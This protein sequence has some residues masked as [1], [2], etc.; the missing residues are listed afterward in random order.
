MNISDTIVI[1]I[2]PWAEPTEEQKRFFDA[3]PTEEKRRL[4][5]EAIEK[6]FDSG[7]SERSMPDIVAK[8]KARLKA[9]EL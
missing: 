2:Y 9:G 7:I 5:R 3:L 4:I 6:G 1:D 8:A